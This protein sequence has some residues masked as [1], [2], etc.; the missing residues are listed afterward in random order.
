M[1]FVL[2]YLCYNAGNVHVYQAIITQTVLSLLFHQKLIV[3]LLSFISSVQTP[4]G[5]IKQEENRVGLN[6]CIQ[7]L[8]LE[9]DS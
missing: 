9:L 8:P 4:I 5:I 2:G 1:K 3:V 7:T 6:L